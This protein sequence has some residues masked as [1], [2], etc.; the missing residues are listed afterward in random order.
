M[1]KFKNFIFLSL[2]ILGTLNLEASSH[3]DLRKAKHSNNNSSNNSSSKSS[4]NSSPTTISELSQQEPVTQNT[5]ID[6]IT[7]EWLFGSE[8]DENT[9]SV[10]KSLE[11]VLQAKLTKT[12][13]LQINEDSQKWVKYTEEQDGLSS[14]WMK[15]E[16]F[17]ETCQKLIETIES[18]SNNCNNNK[19]KQNESNNCILD[20]ENSD[21]PDWETESEDFDWEPLELISK[22]EIDKS[23]QEK[24]I[25][26]GTIAIR[27]R[28]ADC[29]STA[30]K[31]I[32]WLSEIAPS[33]S[34]GN[35]SSSETDNGDQDR[36][37]SQEEYEVAHAY[38]QAMLAA[39]YTN[40]VRLKNAAPKNIT[41]AMNT[42]LFRLKA[43]YAKFYAHLS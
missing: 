2:L 15:A 32:L 19:R 13:N 33:I 42:A 20:S 41:W 36:G 26:N 9:E 30:Q 6:E 14:Q 29:T 43:L 24:F 37:F 1:K 10:Q 28:Y 25:K 35:K 27:T 12:T 38:Q 31:F 34:S 23:H 17:E 39:A 5:L 21:N 4:K 22:S 8:N 18:Q 3:K 40:L 16:K 11:E 7:T